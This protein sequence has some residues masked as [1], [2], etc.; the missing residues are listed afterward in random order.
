MTTEAIS[1]DQLR[2]AIEGALA[3]HL[4]PGP[5]IEPRLAEAMRYAVLGAGKRIRPLLTLSTA[6][7][8]GA[9]AAAAMAP[10]CA[11]ELVHAYSL[12][13]DDLPAMD[14]DDLRRGRPTVHRA[15]DE[16]TAILAGDAL[17]ALAFELLS[18][19]PLP[20]DI[21]IDMISR[22]SAAV[23]AAGMVGGQSIDITATGKAVGLAQLER[24]HDAKTGA[25]LCAAVDLGALAAAAGNETREH[26]VRFGQR[27]GR[28]FQVVDDLLDVTV[29]TDVQGKHAGVDARLGK[30]TFPALLGVDE[31]RA[32]VARLEADALDA[33]RAA[34]ITSGAL[35]EIAQQV[36][37][38]NR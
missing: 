1:L 14:D 26:L 30:C 12:V 6:L 25:L 10:A 21:R 28:A 13:H 27:I 34:G 33:L 3:R 37:N 4:T 19:A 31:S 32:Y 11:V 23:G 7:A 16:A 9:P 38:R 22:L 17:Q 29:A 8:L 35:H 18:T 15:F 5:A 24:M 20:P 2:T 36:V